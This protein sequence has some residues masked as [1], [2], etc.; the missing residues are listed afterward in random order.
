MTQRRGEDVA[1]RAEAKRDDG[2]SG[3]CR[4]SSTPAEMPAPIGAQNSANTSIVGRGKV[5]PRLEQR[6]RTFGTRQLRRV[7]NR[8]RVEK[9]ERAHEARR[10]NIQVVMSALDHRLRP[11]R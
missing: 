7:L 9:I 4:A 10:R 2:F 1:C 6:A 11:A 5:L 8:R 3:T